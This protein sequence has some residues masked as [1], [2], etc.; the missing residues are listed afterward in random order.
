MLR[1]M[2]THSDK[3][4]A[5]ATEVQFRK[6]LERTIERLTLESAEVTIKIADRSHNR[7][8]LQVSVEN[9]TGHKFPTGFPSR[10][11]WIRL[12]VQNSKGEVFFDSGKWNDKG[13]IEGLNTG[14][15]PH[16]DT[17]TS[18]NQVQIYEAIMGDTNG[19]ITYTLLRAAKY[20]KDNRLVPKGYSARGPMS[21]HTVIAGEAAIDPD[22]NKK[23]GKEGTGMDTV[24][25]EISVDDDQFPLTIQS[26]LLYQ[27]AAPR[28]IADLS[29][30]A[31]VAAA[32][33]AKM[34]AKMDK[35]PIVIDAKTIVAK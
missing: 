15:E 12:Q 8:Q 31:T 28:F 14:Y 29:R 10:R 21:V 20:L 3:L 25:Y 30:D 27:T 23:D 18:S 2:M 7:M 17:I 24:T 32:E 5:T 22:F 4:E 13:E 6:T 33:F 1:L 19:D 11:T 34:Y 26:Q 16:H 35:D 9:K